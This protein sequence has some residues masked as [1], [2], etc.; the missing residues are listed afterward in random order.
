MRADDVRGG[1]MIELLVVITMIAVLTAVG[2]STFRAHPYAFDGALT[3]LVSDVRMTRTFAQGRGAHYRL[4]ILDESTYMIERLRF[5]DGAWRPAE[6]D[7][8]RKTLDV[9]VRFRS[10]EGTS[11]EFDTRGM[12]VNLEGPRTI[13]LEERKTGAVRVTQVFPSGQVIKQ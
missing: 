8:R 7:R 2:V 13:A 5:V 10:A 1:S 3:E 11:V 12:A 4:A 6:T 9:S